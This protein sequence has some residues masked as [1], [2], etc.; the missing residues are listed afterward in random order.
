M[1]AD[2]RGA[3]V[4]FK[5]GGA[6]AKAVENLLNNP[7]ELAAMRKKAYQFGRTMIWSEVAKQYLSEFDSIQQR[8][9]EIVS[10][11]EKKKKPILLTSEYPIPKLNHLKTM[12]DDFA[13]LQHA[14][15]TIPNYRHGYCVDD[16]ARAIVVATKFYR[17]MNSD[18][19]L[20]LLRKY[21]AFLMYAQR[22]DGRFRNF[23]SV[24]KKSLDEVGSDD[25]QGRALWGLGYAIA[26]GP[27]F[28]G[29]V[30]YD[31][32]YQL[33]PHIDKVCLRGTA[34]SLL[35]LYYYLIRYPDHQEVLTIMKRL[36]DKMVD[37]FKENTDETWS[38]FE[39]EL[40]Y[41]N[42]LL[43]VSMW[44][45]YYSLKQDK[46]REVAEKASSFLIENSLREGHLSPI[47]CNGWYKK[48]ENR[49]QYDQQPIDTLWMVEL[50][51]FAYRFTQD[52]SY[53][54]LMKTSFDWFLG[55]NDKETPV[56][57]R[58]TGGCFD[59]LNPRGTNINQGAESTLSAVLSLLSITE[60]A[61]Q[62]SVAEE[63]LIVSNT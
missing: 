25:C 35:G 32:F 19:A 2:G 10:L 30:T 20:A 39:D 6:I 13:L 46:Y 21:L 14:R 57:D 59:G 5:D 27:D 24:T 37:D 33:L 50:G 28:Y 1:L 8:R 62:Q 26:Y 23:F 49:A 53:L 56:Y 55:D 36:A 29:T 60:M 16:N 54:E 41:G 44:V 3:V 47:G 34:Y 15:Y 58:V 18:E 7:K 61:H 9:P 48:G 17:L 11:K 42:G 45:S 4:P 52:E 38:W 43:P 12:T 31:T 63:E 22:E 51:K 40:T